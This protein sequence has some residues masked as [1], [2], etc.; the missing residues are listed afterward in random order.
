MDWTWILSCIQ[1]SSLHYI[2][3]KI[4]SNSLFYCINRVSSKPIPAFDDD[5]PD[6]PDFDVIYWMT[7]FVIVLFLV[8]IIVAMVARS[9]INNDSDDDFCDVGV[10]NNSEEQSG[11]NYNHLGQKSDKN[12]GNVKKLRCRQTL[13]SDGNI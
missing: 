1:C 2:L 11:R 5:L 4:S 7:T 9:F 6:D 3:Q 8:T 13:D 10:S 12:N